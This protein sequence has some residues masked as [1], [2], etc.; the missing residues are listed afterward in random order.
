[1]KQK[2]RN[3]GGKVFTQ[4]TFCAFMFVMFLF[5][6]IPLLY[7][8]RYNHAVSD[9][10]W[11]AFHVHCSWL[12]THNLLYV[13]ITAAR[14]S[15][16]FYTS[17]QGTYSS[18]FFMALSP[19]A[20]GEQYAHAVP[21]IIIGMTCVSI[22]VLTYAVLGRW[23]EL[24]R[25]TWTSAAM[26]VCIMQCVFM[27]TPASGLYWW[28]GAVHYVFMQGFWNLMTGFALLS[29]ERMYHSRGRRVW[30]GVEM[31]VCTGAAFM[32]SGGNFS[33][34]LLTAETLVILG[35][36][37]VIL[38]RTQKKKCYLWFIV[39]FLIGE[40]GFLINILAPGNSVRQAHFQKGSVLGSIGD[41]FAYSF[42]QMLS[43]V[44]LWVIVILILLL[45][46]L[47]KA[48]AGSRFSFRYPL[49]VTG[50][51]YC[52]YASMFTPGFYAF[53]AEPLSRNQ[54]IC[55]M[56]LLLYLVLSEVYWCGWMNRRIKAVRAVV[57]AHGK[58]ILRWVAA[59]S[60][61]LLAGIIGFV[62]LDPMAKQVQFANYGACLISID[63]RGQ[64]Y[65]T[66]YLNRLALYK[67]DEKVV[68]V[69]PYSDQP[70][71]IW[72][73]SDTETA[74]DESGKLNSLVAFW[75]GK[76]AIYEIAP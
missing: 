61:A 66:Q 34:A 35:G 17:W 25:Y 20:F 65:W 26:A 68:Y 33:T 44:S 10:Y 53:G 30:C 64:R 39:P 5:F 55:K 15:A 18:I 57:P 38:W 76:D 11:F 3:I 9:D 8:G 40:A 54:N 63:G 12:N 62:K 51:G 73:N 67:S 56:F 45:P 36:G 43:W 47:L 4:K 28:N 59:L 74:S 23:M 2:L 32:A 6:I 1:M 72:L 41:S 21:Y 7:V 31:A 13:F 42:T 75:Y 24:N 16:E 19:F 69:H 52:L 70:Y 60:L 22:A 46:I 14:K 48:V 49:L 27:Y 29:F 71:P 58:N 37:A 50:M